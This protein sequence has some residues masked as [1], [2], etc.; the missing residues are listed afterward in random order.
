MVGFSS[1]LYRPLVDRDFSLRWVGCR[2]SMTTVIVRTCWATFQNPDD[3]NGDA[4]DG[5]WRCNTTRKIRRYM[6]SAMLGH[7]NQDYVRTAR[8]KGERSNS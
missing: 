4:R 1:R 8:A 6:R 3:A 5:C 7:L 2:R